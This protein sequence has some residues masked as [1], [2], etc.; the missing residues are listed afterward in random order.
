MSYTSTEL[1]RLLRGNVLRVE[2]TKQD[3]SNRVMM[4][5]LMD[6]YLPEYEHSKA[7]LIG[8]SSSAHMSVWDIEANG[9]RSFRLES[10]KSVLVNGVQY[11]PSRTVLTEAT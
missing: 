4:A 5:T 6:H 7:Q 9:W 3:G 2:F 8:E 11:K 10:I 1:H